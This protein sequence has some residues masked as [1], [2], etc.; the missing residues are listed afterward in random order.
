MSEDKEK[1]RSWEEVAQE[2]SERY[3][4]PLE[5]VEAIILDYLGLLYYSLTG[6]EPCKGHLLD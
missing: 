6:R 5:I 3:N 4:I 2:L 1:L